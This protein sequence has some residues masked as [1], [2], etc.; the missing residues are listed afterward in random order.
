M[1]EIFGK[2]KF[3]GALEYKIS[4]EEFREDLGKLIDNEKV[5]VGYSMDGKITGN[6]YSFFITFENPDFDLEEENTVVQLTEEVIPL[7][8]KHVSNLDKFD[9][10]QVQF[11]KSVES[12]NIERKQSVIVT[13]NITTNVTD[14]IK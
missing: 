14:E 13:Q 7:I 8:A 11:I 1:R 12:D 2:D 9:S 10:Y 4:S 6:I 3:N 5:S